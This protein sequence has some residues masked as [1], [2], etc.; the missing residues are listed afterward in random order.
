MT[1]EDFDNI[2]ILIGAGFVGVIIVAY[3]IHTRKVAA[4]K[5]QITT[6]AREQYDQWRQ[7]DYNEMV[8]Q[9]TDV[10]MRKAQAELS[11][12]RVD[13]EAYIRQDAIARSRAVIVGKVVEHLAPYNPLIF[14]YNPKDA[15]FIGSP[16]DIIV[17]DGCDEGSIREVVFLEIKSG[18]SG[19][20]AR[21]RQIREAVESGRV[22]WRVLKA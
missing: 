13:N 21:Q 4:L 12:W 1:P 10:A 16:I 18:T 17:F 7:R 14:P 22:V 15:R 8:S 20:S 9:Q 5:A 2:V 11:Q 19:L 3:V 6:L